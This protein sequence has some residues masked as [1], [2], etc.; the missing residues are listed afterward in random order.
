M[1]WLINKNSNPDVLINRDRCVSICKSDDVSMAVCVYKIEFRDRVG[2]DCIA[3]VFD[4]RGERDYAFEQ[5]RN[6]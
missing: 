4:D 1:V 2:K 5:I 3:W 6:L